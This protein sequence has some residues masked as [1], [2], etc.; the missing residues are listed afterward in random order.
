MGREVNPI[1][2]ERF[3]SSAIRCC[4]VNTLVEFPAIRRI[5]QQQVFF[6]RGIDASLESHF[7]QDI[8]YASRYR[9]RDARRES[10]FRRLFESI[11]RLLSPL[12]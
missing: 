1:D 9:M 10:F 8:R 2:G 7:R 11:A 4:F 6:D 5:S 3:T 12:L